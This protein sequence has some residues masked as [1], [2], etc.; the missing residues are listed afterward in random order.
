VIGATTSDMSNSYENN[1]IAHE[2]IRIPSRESSTGNQDISSNNISN[3]GDNNYST[4]DN[5]RDAMDPEIRR[6]IELRIYTLVSE[7]LG[8]EGMNMIKRNMVTL[9]I[10]SLKF[11]FSTQASKWF[12][13]WAKVSICMNSI[14]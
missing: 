4:D 6:I 3:N 10:H 7:L 13:A 2:S 14:I 8:I 12:H 1:T 9:L 5:E 11:I